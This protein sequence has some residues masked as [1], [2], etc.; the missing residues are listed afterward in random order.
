MQTIADLDNKF[1]TYSRSIDDQFL[2][3]QSKEVSPETG[4]NTIN[5]LLVDLKTIIGREMIIRSM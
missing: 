5:Q 3:V 1:D 2:M 4:F